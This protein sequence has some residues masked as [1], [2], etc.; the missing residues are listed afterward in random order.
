MPNALI[1]ARKKSAESAIAVLSSSYD[2]P[3]NIRELENLVERMVAVSEG[4]AILKEHIPLEYRI[5]DLQKRQPEGG[6]LNNA[7]ELFEQKFILNALEKTGW[8]RKMT[9]EALGLPLSTLKFKMK[10]LNLSGL[11]KISKKIH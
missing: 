11:D 1:S 3:G 10:K 6:L 4:D 8:R 7:L 2:W 9:A 5:G